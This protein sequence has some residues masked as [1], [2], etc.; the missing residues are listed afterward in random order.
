MPRLRLPSN[1]WLTLLAAAAAALLVLQALLLQRLAQVRPALQARLEAA[2]Q[3]ADGVAQWQAAAPAG[4]MREA[5]AALSADP[6]LAR[7]LIQSSRAHQRLPAGVQAQLDF[8]EQAWQAETVQAQ[9]QYRSAW[10][11][12]RA[13]RQAGEAAPTLATRYTAGLDV[14]ATAFL[15]RL[16]AWQAGEQARL[17]E[18]RAAEHAATLAWRRGWTLAL[19]WAGLLAASLSALLLR[20]APRQAWQWFRQR[21]RPA[22]ECLSSP[23]GR[24]PRALL[25]GRWA[26]LASVQFFLLADQLCR[27]TDQWAD[28]LQWL[29]ALLERLSW[30]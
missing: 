30:R 12:L 26:A 28:G 8:E 21:R 24:P 15:T 6:D 22:S 19:L 9:T 5:A 16:N 17:A 11:A 25:M 14:A 10:Q 7:T 2:V 3:V 4:L 27:T 23:A 18:A 20:G 13:A 1:R 29:G